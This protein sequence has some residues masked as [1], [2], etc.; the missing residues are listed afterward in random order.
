VDVD[1]DWGSET[2][3]SSARTVKEGAQYAS[4][5]VMASSTEGQQQPAKPAAQKVRCAAAPLCRWDAGMQ[6]LQRADGML[7]AFMQPI[8]LRDLL[9]FV[10][11][12]DF[13]AEGLAVIF[14]LLYTAN[15]FLGSR[16]NKRIATAWVEEYARE[17]QLLSRNFAHVGLGECPLR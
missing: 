1:D 12:A 17:G 3:I 7:C 8:P 13:W 5:D 15:I 11:P 6:R 9:K 14:M 16:A 4:E 10:K 2:F